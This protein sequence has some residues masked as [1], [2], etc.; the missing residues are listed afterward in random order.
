MIILE[1]KQEKSNE[2][3]LALPDIEEYHKHYIN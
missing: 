2:G 1:I 3:G